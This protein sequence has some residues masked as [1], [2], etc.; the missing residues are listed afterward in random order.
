MLARRSCRA[1]W[2]HEHVPAFFLGWRNVAGGC[3][4]AKR[5]TLSDPVKRFIIERLAQYASHATV[6][7]EVAQEFGLS[8]SRQTVQRYDPSS[9]AGAKLSK[10]L[11]ELHAERRAT[12]LKDVDSIPVAAQVV[13]LRTLERLAAKAE[14]RGDLELAADI[15]AQVA[16]ER[17]GLFTNKYAAVVEHK[18]LTPTDPYGGKSEQQLAEQYAAEIH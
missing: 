15:L 8:L 18:S 12:F 14:E 11:R 13:R 6:V 7:A 17:G 4:M 1:S 3:Q 16:K 10:R 9:R 2:R 5:K